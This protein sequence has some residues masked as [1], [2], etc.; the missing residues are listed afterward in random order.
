MA[1]RSELSLCLNPK[2]LSS[3]LDRSFEET[4]GVFFFHFS[5]MRLETAGCSFFATGKGWSFVNS[6]QD[7]APKDTESYVKAMLEARWCSGMVFVGI[8]P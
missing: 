8:E 4:S 2:Q 7:C 6:C 1:P 5:K 3:G